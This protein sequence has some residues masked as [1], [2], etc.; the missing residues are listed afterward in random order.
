MHIGW[1]RRSH[2]ASFVHRPSVV[3]AAASSPVAS[4]AAA[5]A[6][7]AV[8]A[9]SPVASLEVDSTL[10]N[11]I[12]IILLMIILMILLSNNGH[13]LSNTL[14]NIGRRT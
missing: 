5:A 3:A 9:S 2:K 13:I 14:Y 8:A 7:L 12:L 4:F 6:S 10:P 1:S 11:I